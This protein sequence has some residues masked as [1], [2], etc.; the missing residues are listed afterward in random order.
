MLFPVNSRIA[1][2]FPGSPIQQ[3]PDFDPV[4][5]D[6]GFDINGIIADAM[7]RISFFTGNF[8]VLPGIS[9]RSVR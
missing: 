6:L 1:D 3:F 9:R 2:M 5:A 7:H 4:F 8:P